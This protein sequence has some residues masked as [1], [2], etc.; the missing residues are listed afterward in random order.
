MNTSREGIARMR[1]RSQPADLLLINF[2]LVDAWVTAIPWIYVPYYPDSRWRKWSRKGLKF[3]KR[4]LRAP[5]I[6]RILGRGTVVPKEEYRRNIRNI[7]EIER[8]RN[9]DVDVVLWSCVRTRDN[10]SRDRLLSDYNEV[11]RTLSEELSTRFFDA[12]EQIREFPHAET[13][14]DEVHLSAAAAAF[15]A[16]R[17]HAELASDGHL[18]RAA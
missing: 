12:A 13:Y 4:R 17:L 5:W 14:L 2:G 8:G 3:V 16:D 7:V 10:P 9:P 18:T 15:L 1:D 11:L 6:R